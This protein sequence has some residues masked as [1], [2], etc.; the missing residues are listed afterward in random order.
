MPTFHIFHSFQKNEILQALEQI[1]CPIQI[2][3]N[4]SNRVSRGYPIKSFQSLAIGK[5]TSDSHQKRIKH[6]SQI[7]SEVQLFDLFWKQ[8]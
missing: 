6:I 8:T 4:G 2:Y 5:D 7:R 1:E 3:K